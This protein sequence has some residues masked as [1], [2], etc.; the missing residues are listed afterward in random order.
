MFKKLRENKFLFEE[1]VKRDFKKKYTRTVLGVFWSLL[2][3]LL[4]LLVM[5]LV[6]KQFF[7]RNTPHYTIYLFCGTLLFNWYKEA[8]KGGMAALV[9]NA[10]IFTKVNV[11]K[12]LFL[13]SKNIQ[14]FI[15][16]I[17]TLVIFAIFLAFD[18]IVPTW[19]FVLLI[20]PIICLIFFNIGVGMVLSALNVFFRDIAYLYDIFCMLLSYLSAIFY[21]IDRFDE[22]VQRYFMLNPMYC[23]ISYFREVVIDASIPGP[24]HHALCAGFALVMIIIGAWTYR[25]YNQ[26]F[27]YYL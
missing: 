10:N 22:S 26:K 9:S 18:K 13:L 11:P 27:L 5:S 17:L 6:F 24:Y 19:R 7:G 12:Y 4:Q 14:A 15:N 2:S 23:Y 8:T 1:L 16:F 20:Y 3:P 21:S 25:H